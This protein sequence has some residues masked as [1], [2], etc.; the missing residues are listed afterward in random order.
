MNQVLERG[1]LQGSIEVLVLH[2]DAA[3]TVVI[4]QRAIF[5]VAVIK[6]RC[7]QRNTPLLHQ[8]VDLLL[9]LPASKLELLGTLLVASNTFLHFPLVISN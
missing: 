2:L 3:L 1:T 7:L 9:E 5:F 8:V 4:Q 6:E